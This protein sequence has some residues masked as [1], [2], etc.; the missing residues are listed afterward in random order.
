MFRFGICNP[1]DIAAT[2]ATHTRAILRNRSAMQGVIESLHTLAVSHIT[3]SRSLA[4]VVRQV[5]YNLIAIDRDI[6]E[7]FRETFID[8]V[9][10]TFFEFWAQFLEYPAQRSTLHSDA[11]KSAHRLAVCAFIG[12]LL[13]AGMLTCAK[14]E[15]CAVYLMHRVRSGRLLQCIYALFAHGCAHRPCEVSP[16]FLEECMAILRGRCARYLGFTKDAQYLRVLLTALAF[17]A[18][19]LTASQSFVHFI[20]PHLDLNSAITA[21]VCHA[22]CHS[23]GSVGGNPSTQYSSGLGSSTGLPRVSPVL[24]A[25][26]ASSEELLELAVPLTTEEP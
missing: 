11:L 3:Y 14:F 10:Y 15:W 19:S 21:S 8:E 26:S 23:D 16:G 7:A 1:T 6:A 12:D 24:S 13:Y 20:D 4:L 18:R 5:L 2:A 25:S 17:E 22:A 9:T